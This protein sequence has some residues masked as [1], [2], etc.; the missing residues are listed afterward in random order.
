M[1][2]FYLF[3]LLIVLVFPGRAQK[4]AGF[5]DVVLEKESSWNG[6]DGSGSFKSS[7]LT[8]K[9]SYNADWM[10]WSGFACSNITD[11]RTKGWGNQYSAIT[12]YG[13]KGSAN[14]AVAYVV[15]FSSAEFET[16][17]IIRGLYITNATYAYWS[18][19]EGDDFTKKFGGVS[20]TDPDYFKVIVDGI[21]ASGKKTAG[22]EF[23]L[24]DFRFGDPLKDYIIKDWTWLDLSSLGV[25]KSVNFKLESSDVGMWGMNTPAYFCVDDVNGFGPVQLNDISYASFDDVVDPGNI[26]YNGADLSGGFYSGNF[27]L[28]NEYIE[29]WGSW[30][31]FAASSM[32]DSQTAGWGNQ[33][34]AITGRGVAGS[35]AYAVAYTGSGKSEILLK[36]A[37]ISGFYV[38]NSAYA[39]WSMKNG[40]DYS[41][42]FGGTSGTDPDWFKLTVKGYT[43]IEYKGHI[44]F[45]LADFR[46][47]NSSGDYIVSDWRWV[48]LSALGEVSRLE[49]SLSSSDE[50]IWGMN[51]PAYFVMDNLN[52]QIPSSIHP[53][54]KEIE[55]EVY[56]NP[57]SNE[58]KVH[59][60]NSA[61]EILLYD[62]AGKQLRSFNDSGKLVTLRGL[63]DLNPGIYFL[64]ITT[65]NQ[66]VI[67]KMIKK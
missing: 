39:Y 19:K 40:D 21:D 38:S 9:N 23:Y 4:A 11:N 53:D 36:K 25:V 49:F 28:K 31:G 33:Y 24:A 65:E 30:S 35:A 12:G 20:G 43:D 27:Y 64:K 54:L 6:S 62:I 45:Y 42:K 14:Y 44:D 10:S 61:D 22:V 66:S 60:N 3:F 55:A 56:P 58:L 7:N 52:K 63:G 16:A 41:K 67:K 26:Y 8:F 13:C 17:Q 32:T 48:D 46:S 1:K 47:A 50:G 37:T 59:L 57:F 29:S 34:S 2:H 18:M 5:E 15:G 51:T